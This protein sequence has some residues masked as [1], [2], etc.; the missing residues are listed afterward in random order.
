M[1]RLALACVLAGCTSFEDPDIVVDL[2]VLAMTA[3]HPEQVVEVDLSRPPQPSELLAQLVPTRVCA[4]VA[5]PARDR[6]VRW[7]MTVCLADRS[8]CDEELFTPIGGGIA[9]DPET[10]V[11]APEMCATVEPNGNLLG[12]LVATAEGDALAA[13]GGIDYYVQLTARGEDEPAAADQFATKT[14]R[15][16]PKIP[17]IRTPNQN[18]TVE[19]FDVTLDGYEPAP[20]PLGRC[21]EQTSPLEVAPGTRIKIEPVELPTTRE[22]YVVPTLDGKVAMFMES[23]TYQWVADAGGFSRGNSGGTRDAVGNLPELFTEWRAPA[24]RDVSEPTDVRLWFIARDERLGATWYESC[25][26]VVP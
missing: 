16:S 17:T 2:R 3:E 14:L 8:R 20:M 18:P 11:T 7:Q 24:A 23:P 9:D 25:V 13:L 15:V 12:I 1:K 19:R 21:A 10:S 4:L 22:T 6:R 26:R 5:D